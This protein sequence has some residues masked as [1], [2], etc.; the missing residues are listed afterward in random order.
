METSARPSQIDEA[1]E[2]FW[3]FLKTEL[4]PYPGR[5]WVVGRITISATIVMLLVMTFRLPGGFLGA[6][7]T[8]FLSRENPVATFS[9]G[10][11]TVV[12]FLS[13]TAYTAFTC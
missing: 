13:A 11:K 1:A 10:L 3:Q 8:L 12:A 9:A 5:A 4:T 6:V 7:F 2:W